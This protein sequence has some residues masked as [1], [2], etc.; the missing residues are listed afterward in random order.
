MSAWPKT[1]TCYVHGSKEDMWSDGGKLGLEGEPLMLFR[2]ALGE[3]TVTIAVNQ[4]G[5][6]KILEVKE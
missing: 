2:H 3:L 6:Y 5:T 1:V 4:D